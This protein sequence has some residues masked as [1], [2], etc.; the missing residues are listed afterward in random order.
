M[1]EWRINM[2]SAFA[3]LAMLAMLAIPMASMAAPPAWERIDPIAP[4]DEFGFHDI[5]PDPR[6]PG[7]LYLGTDTA[8]VYRSDNYGTS[9]SRV[10]PSGY[11]TGN[12]WALA[13][14]RFN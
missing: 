10:S 6:I 2:R 3:I 4:P 8:G 11:F 5:E 12:N 1:H 7:R 14:D 9:W 13:V